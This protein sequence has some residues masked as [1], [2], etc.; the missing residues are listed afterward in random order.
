[1]F[2]TFLAQ[3]HVQPAQQDALTKFLQQQQNNQLHHQN[4]QHNNQVSHQNHQ[5]HINNQH[6]QQFE[7]QHLPFSMPSEQQ[8]HSDVH[9]L[10]RDMAN[11]LLTQ[12]PQVAT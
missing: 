11:G 2:Q 5:Q 4:K 1:M 10:M 12:H 7:Q 3:H 9:A 6:Q 8:H